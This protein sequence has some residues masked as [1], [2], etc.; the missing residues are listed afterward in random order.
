MAKTRTR[1]ITIDISE[2]RFSSIFR[3]LKLKGKITQAQDFSDI[4]ALRQVLNNEKS[5]ILHTIKHQNP[6]SIYHLAKLL[7]R[8]FKSVRQDVKL[9]ERFGFIDLV[10]DKK[11]NR[12]RLKPV[13]AADSVH[14]TFNV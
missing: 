11:G 13:L 8:D 3:R 12:Q 14:I 6:Q 4:A 10:S 7:A 2:G 5:R 9:L 1:H